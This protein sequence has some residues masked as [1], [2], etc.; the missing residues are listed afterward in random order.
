[1]SHAKLSEDGIPLYLYIASISEGSCGLCV[2]SNIKVYE[3]T[4]IGFELPRHPNCQCVLVPFDEEADLKYFSR[5]SSVSNR[6][7]DNSNNR[8]GIDVDTVLDVVQTLLDVAGLIPVVGEI[9]DG[10]NALISLGR[11]NYVDA[12]LSV[13]SMVPVEGLP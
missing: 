1:M 2:A 6:D 10:A 7:D 9:F 5:S 12:A 3:E 8:K 4:D 13:A 11:G